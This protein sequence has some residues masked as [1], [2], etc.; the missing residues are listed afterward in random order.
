[1]MNDLQDPVVIS[2][3]G[4]VSPYGIDKELLWNVLF[5]TKSEI[6]QLKKSRIGNIDEENGLFIP[7][8]WNPKELLGKRG[9]QF[10]NASTKYLMAATNLALEHAQLSSETVNAEELGVV[11]GC[12]YTGLAVSIEYDQIAITEGPRYVSPMQA[13]NILANAPA[14]HLGIRVQAQACNTTISTDQCAGLD[15]L[16][17]SMNLLKRNRAKY[18]IVGGVEELNES[19]I[20]YLK[21]SGHT[22]KTM[23]DKQGIPYA[24]DSA[25]ILP[26]EGAVTVILERKSTAIDRGIQPLAELVSWDNVFAARKDESHRVAAVRRALTSVVNA[27]SASIEDIG[28][29]FSGANGDYEIDRVEL[30]AL[31]ELLEMGEKQVN[32]P[33]VFPIKSV[34]GEAFGASGLFQLSG[35]LGVLNKKKCPSP[36][37]NDADQVDPTFASLL[38]YNQAWTEENECP[39]I[40]LT[41]HSRSGETSAILIRST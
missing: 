17:Y 23:T 18:V 39:Y 16:G 27:A 14:S 20:Q 41:S 22:P 6:D 7:S 38:N 11:V 12:N 26:S 25:G 13:P 1:M 36:Y 35:A 3:I 24:P 10:L 19:V 37:G 30:L 4:Q 29:I 2:G 28:L 9:L 33:K 32:S 31:Q 5:K 8:D 15:A 40:A 21:R 34:V